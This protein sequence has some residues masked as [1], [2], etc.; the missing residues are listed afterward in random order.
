MSL[1]VGSPAAAPF[2][3][4]D[5]V[6]DAVWLSGKLGQAVREAQV[7]DQEK[8]GGMS[9]E[10]KYIDVQLASGDTLALVLKTAA[11]TA[12]R[13]AMSLSREAFF[14]NE[15]APQLEG[16]PKSYHA[17]G[18]LRTGDML[19]LME[20]FEGAIP[21]GTFFGPGNPNNWAVKDKLTDMCLGNPTAL[22][23]TTANFKLYAQ[24]HGRFWQDRT[25]L[26]KEWLRG[27]NWVK[28]EG[29][30]AWEGAQA[31]AVDAW[32]KVGVSR[33][34]GTSSVEW[35][36]HVVA[37]LDASFA[38]VDWDAFQ[39][40]QETLPF[41]LVHGDAHPHNALWVDQ[42]TDAARLRLIDFEMVGVGSPGQEAGASG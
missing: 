6:V 2:L 30:A 34:A 36:P 40:G 25:L 11:G 13:V 16:V 26:D 3:S 20:C 31:M 10:I 28:G 21:A 42:R 8:M 35:D 22:E 27:T 32:T 38:K 23:I 1:T 17:E 18:N 33:A 29:R 9:G 19:L 41:A 15:F 7:R 14:Y 12:T 5:G 39:A 37:C 4:V 24:L